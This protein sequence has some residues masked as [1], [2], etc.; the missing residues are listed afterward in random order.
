[1]KSF[2]YSK[3]LTATTSQQTFTLP[4][5]RSVRVLNYG[6]NNVYIE[7]EN[8]IDD[9]SIILPVR[10]DIQVPADMQ[11]MRYKSLS[12]E[13]TIYIYGLRHEKI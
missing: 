7:F 5:L 12:G 2:Y 6:S 9:D 8:N 4:R 1:M 11:D 13:A 10:G 3:K